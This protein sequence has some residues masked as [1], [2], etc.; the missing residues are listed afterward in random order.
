[1]SEKDNKSFF[2]IINLPLNYLK[3]NLFFD[4]RKLSVGVNGG[5]GGETDE[6][7]SEIVECVVIDASVGSVILCNSDSTILTHSASFITAICNGT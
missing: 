3:E 2:L 1:M 5:S 4:V 7:L 6:K